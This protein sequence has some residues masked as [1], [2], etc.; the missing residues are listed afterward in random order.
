MFSSGF[1]S[2][3]NFLS[4]LFDIRF[5]FLVLRLSV[6][7]TRNISSKQE[8]PND[9]NLKLFYDKHIKTSLLAFNYLKRVQN[10][11]LWDASGLKLIL[12]NAHPLKREIIA[13]LQLFSS[14]FHL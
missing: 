2:Y 4:T 9:D 5:L 1:H 8:T 12:I 10:L 7:A 13:V 6:L 11:Q 3:L 14:V